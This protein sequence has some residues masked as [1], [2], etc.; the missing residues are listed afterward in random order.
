M[1]RLAIKGDAPLSATQLNLLGV[2]VGKGQGGE[3]D[4]QRGKEA[5]AALTE[6]LK[7]IDI[8]N[9][10]PLDALL[11]LKKLKDNLDE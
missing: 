4:G 8:D 11:R 5:Q 10:T 9:L 7:A 6:E 3:G 1:P 2:Q